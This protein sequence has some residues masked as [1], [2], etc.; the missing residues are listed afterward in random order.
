MEM[1]A[2]SFESL[3]ERKVKSAL[4]IVMVMVGSS[5]LVA[6]N[7]IGAG[8]VD[9]FNQQF[10][11]LAPN[12]LFVSSV[13]Q[14]QDSGGGGGI[15]SAGSP[16]LSAKITLNAAVVN[17]INSLPFIDDVIPSYQSQITIESQGK[18]KSHNVLSL[19]PTK[20]CLLLHLHWNL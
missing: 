3:K 2:L 4:T 8:F 10:S 20:A 14:N 7:G 6:V 19:D 12:L 18:S 17:R 16:S 13:Q 11:N 5:L 15:G 9:F 1:F